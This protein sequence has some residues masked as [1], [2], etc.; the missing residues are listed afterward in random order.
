MGC[1]HLFQLKRVPSTQQQEEVENWNE[2]R[3]FNFLMKLRELVRLAIKFL[4]RA[5]L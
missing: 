1:A 5:Y 2:E 3:K 4:S